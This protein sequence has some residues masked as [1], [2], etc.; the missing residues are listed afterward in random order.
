MDGSRRGARVRRASLLTLAMLIAGAG[1][2]GA[3]PIRTPRVP[4]ADFLRAGPEL[5]GVANT[6]IP[7]GLPLRLDGQGSPLSSLFRDYILYRRGLDPS[8]FDAHHPRIA[9][10]IARFVP[11]A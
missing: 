9:R 10:Q 3:A 6:T 11:P 4:F 7:H 1:T 2:A 5:W 8:R